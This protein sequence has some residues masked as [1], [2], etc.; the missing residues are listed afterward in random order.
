[1]SEIAREAGVSRERLY[2]ARSTDGNPEFATVM[3]VAHALGLRLCV[4][5]NK[6]A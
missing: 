2:R 1:M 5:P 4:T 3:R 6:G